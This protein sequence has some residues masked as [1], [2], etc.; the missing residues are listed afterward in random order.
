MGIGKRVAHLSNLPLTEIETAVEKD[1][2]FFPFES[3]STNKNNICTREKATKAKDYF[4]RRVAIKTNRANDCIQSVFLKD[5]L[6]TI[7]GKL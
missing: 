7:A 6:E 5:F 4:P 2:Q 3:D 1:M